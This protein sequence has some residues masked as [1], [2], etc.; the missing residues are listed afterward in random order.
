MWFKKKNHVFPLLWRGV[1]GEESYI[2]LKPSEASKTEKTMKL[3]GLKKKITFSL[4]FG[5]GLGERRAIFFYNQAKRLKPIKL[6]NYVVKKKNHVFPLLCRGVRG[7]ESYVF[8]K[9]SEVSK[10]NKTMKLCGLKK[11]I[12]FSLSFGEGLGERRA[13]FF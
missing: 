9:P 5:E 13:I 6:W 1:R 2:F 8:L 3:C 4:S 10:A 7:E 12:T 11:K